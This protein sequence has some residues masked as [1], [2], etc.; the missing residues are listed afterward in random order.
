[1]NYDPEKNFGPD[2]VDFAYQI[3]NINQENIQLRNELKHC[4]E[5]LAIHQKSLNKQFDHNNEIIGMVM[6]AAID[7]D[8]SI[9]KGRAAILKEKPISKLPIEIDEVNKK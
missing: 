2:V 5:L 1:M 8:S 6:K 7:P 9:N 3:I 4:K